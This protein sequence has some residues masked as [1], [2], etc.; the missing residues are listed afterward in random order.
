MSTWKTKDI[1]K[2]L[3]VKGF[4][5]TNTH[6]EMYWLYVGTRKTSVRTRISH[7]ESEYG[8]RLLNQMAK[9]VGLNRAEFDE[10]IECPLSR[11]EYVQL[12]KTRGIVKLGKDT[13]SR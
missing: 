8:D 5:E 4:Q 12:L 1:R 9:Q 11:D 13:P 2:S 10:L 7:S 3:L 6:H